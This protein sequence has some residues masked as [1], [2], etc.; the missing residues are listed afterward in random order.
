MVMT[1]IG[2]IDMMLSALAIGSTSRWLGLEACMRPISLQ[3]SLT[4][5]D[6]Q[7]FALDIHMRC[8]Q[9]VLFVCSPRLASNSRP[10]LA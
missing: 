6:H 3:A 8:K 4:L 7:I 9:M 5:S 10:L 2:A 1:T